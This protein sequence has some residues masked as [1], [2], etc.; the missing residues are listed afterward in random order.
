MGWRLL[1]GWHRRWRGVGDLRSLGGDGGDGDAYGEGS[2][3]GGADAAGPQASLEA[4]E[5]DDDARPPL[6][7]KTGFAR[8]SRGAG[9][10]GFLEGRGADGPQGARRAAGREPR[11]PY[12]VME[13]GAVCLRGRAPP[14]GGD[15]VPAPSGA[16]AARPHLGGRS[17]AKQEVHEPRAALRWAPRL[18]DARGGHAGGHRGDEGVRR[19]ES[20]GGWGLR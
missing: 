15:D 10:W 16:G 11:D 4:R 18:Y 7:G 20:G 5:G 9:R 17:V 6:G 1:L 13:W 12:R 8:R 2:H 3:R 14:A 19:G